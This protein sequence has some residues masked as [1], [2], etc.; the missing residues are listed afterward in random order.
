M[1]AT[2]ATLE[3]FEAAALRVGVTGALREAVVGT[4]VPTTITDKYDPQ[5]YRNLGYLDPAGVEISFD[6]DATEFIPWQEMVAIRRNTTKSVK[7]VKITL[8]QFTKDNAAMFFGIPGGRVVVNADGSWYF[9]EFGV[10]EFE[11]KQISIDVV[12]G[13]KAMRIVLL[14][15]Q[16]TERSGITLKREDAIGLQMTLS[17][18][19]AGSAYA[20][21]GLSGRTARWMFTSSWD[22]TGATGANSSST[23][24]VSE[25]QVQTLA[26]P[27]GTKGKEYAAW[28]SALGGTS[29]Y[30]F[31]VKDGGPL[32]TGLELDENGFLHGTPTVGGVK[33]L[34]IEVEDAKRMKADRQIRLTIAGGA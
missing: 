32:H 3:G 23:D 11:H 25:L 31:T 17:T 27:D 9:D 16:V 22:A 15:A 26:L 14:D 34:T 5:I 12:D 18:Y 1:A 8:W 10:P 2:Q 4:N 29:P 20:E 13:D 21:Q 6:E 30:K 28:L 33:N 7:A 24:G 19:P